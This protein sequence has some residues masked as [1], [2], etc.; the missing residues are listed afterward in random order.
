MTA[1][2]TAYPKFK[3]GNEGLPNQKNRCFPWFQTLDLARGK[4]GLN[5][6]WL[7]RELE[8][9]SK[10]TFDTYVANNLSEFD[11]F[12]GLSGSSLKTGR[13]AKNRGGVYI[14]D[15]G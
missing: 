11:I 2:F 12:Y 3:L 10:Q 5:H 8:W 9:W 14:C 7:T 15:R 1:I 4:F 6:P 13:I